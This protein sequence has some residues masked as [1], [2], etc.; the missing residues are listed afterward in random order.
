ML[1]RENCN[2]HIPSDKWNYVGKQYPNK[3]WVTDEGLPLD[4]ERCLIVYDGNLN[5]ECEP[6]WCWNGAIYSEKHKA[7]VITPNS[8]IPEKNVLCWIRQDEGGCMFFQY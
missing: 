5:F 3:A 1:M 4:K 2:F 8:A 6:M 7:F